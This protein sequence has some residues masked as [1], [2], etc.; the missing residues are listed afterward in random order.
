[1]PRPAALVVVCNEIVL[2][3]RREIVELGSGV[4]TV[5]LARLM[6]E[7]D[8]RL[9]ALEHDPDWA[10]VVRS[11]LKR[12]ALTHVARLVDAPLEAH[13]LGLEGAHWYAE[14]AVAVLPD[15]EIDLLVDGPPGYGE[16]MSEAA[17][18]RCRRSIR[19]RAGRDGGAG[20]CA[21][22]RRARD[23]R[24][25][26]PSSGGGSASAGTRCRDRHARAH[27]GSA[28][29]LRLQVLLRLL[30]LRLHDLDLV[31]DLGPLLADWDRVRR[32]TRQPQRVA[33]V[34]QGIGIVDVAGA[35]GA[36]EA[37]NRLLQDSGSRPRRGP[38]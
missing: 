3:D 20:R 31:R 38:G 8:G 25:P 29:L 22:A 19:G 5:V 2:A 28:L 11:Q 4:S 14:Q 9:T 24:A 15:R 13:P 10:R 26:G 32:A 36:L 35:A 17:T 18:R 12:E 34:V 16:G 6:R 27:P 1:M 21:S 37:V 30:E 23:H 7:R 33:E